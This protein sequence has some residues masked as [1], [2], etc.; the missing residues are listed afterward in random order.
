MQINDSRPFLGCL[1]QAS[2]NY[3]IK[4]CRTPT[5]HIAAAV[6]SYTH[7]TPSCGISARA[8]SGRTGQKRLLANLQ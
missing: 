4:E 8:K 6:Y 2:P 5:M 7:W 1:D 3:D